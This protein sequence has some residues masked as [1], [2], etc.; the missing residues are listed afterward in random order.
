MHLVPVIRR[1]E[2]ASINSFA[3][4]LVASNIMLKKKGT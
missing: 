4:G 3:N 2:S 1:S